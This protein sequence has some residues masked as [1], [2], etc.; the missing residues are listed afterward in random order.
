MYY[1][2][3]AGGLLLTHKILY[4]GLSIAEFPASEEQGTWPN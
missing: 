3:F 4:K 2:D 1:A